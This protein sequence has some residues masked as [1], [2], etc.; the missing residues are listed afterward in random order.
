MAIAKGKTST[1]AK[2]KATKSKTKKSPK[3]KKIP[4]HRQLEDLSR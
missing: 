2:D 4:Y 1:T 3:G